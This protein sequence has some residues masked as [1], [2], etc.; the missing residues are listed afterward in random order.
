MKRKKMIAYLLLMSSLFIS[1]CNSGNQPSSKNSE[2]TSSSISSENSISLIEQTY[3]INISEEEYFDKTYG[4]LIAELWG[5]FSGLPTE[6]LYTGT[7]NPDYVPWM[8]SS[9]YATDDDTSLEYV[10]THA[11]ETYGVN[12]ITYKDIVMEWQ[13]HIRDYIWCGNESAKRLMDQGYLP[14]FTGKIGYNQNYRAIDAQIECEIFGMISP[15]M[16]E[17]AK[18]RC[19]WWLRSVGDG[20]AIECASFYSALVAELYIAE[21]VQSAIENVL[22]LF[23][24]NTSAYRVANTVLN[25]KKKHPEYTWE[26]ARSILLQT[27]YKNN[28]TLDCEINFAMVIMSLIYGESDFEKT[29]QI[30]LRAGFDNDCNAATT[31]LMMGVFLGYSKLP[32]ELKTKSGDLYINTNRP[33]LGDDTVTNWA[34]RVNELGKKVIIAADGKVDSDSLKVNDCEFVSNPY[35]VEDENRLPITD[36]SIINKGFTKIY[37]KDFYNDFG[38][39]TDTKDA[40]L[41]FNFTGNFVTVYAL[42]CLDAGSFKVYLD[43][44][45][46]G[47]I[48]LEQSS[49]LTLNKEINQ[50]A[51]SLVKRIYN[52]ENTQHTLKIVSLGDETIELDSIGYGITQP[53]ESEA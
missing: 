17:N 30:S 14:P 48:S 34:K 43:D 18:T 6:F 50:I 15:G 31:C 53:Y 12:D 45:P 27:Y 52:L 3:D 49:T 29:G 11:M 22:E 20:G 28:N 26:Q 40:T 36:E 8:V 21:S 47:T 51:Q 33:G 23:E 16:K 10:W 37:N 4:G 46:Y 7:P 13:N 44:E 1:G 19:D 2:T 24:T 39:A 42:T 5:N 35:W 41:E 9:A 38:Y 32:E 25:I